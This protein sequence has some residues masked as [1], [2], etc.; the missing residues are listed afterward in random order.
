MDTTG[1][2]DLD[3][4]SGE[5]RADSLERAVRRGVLAIRRRFSRLKSTNRAIRQGRVSLHINGSNEAVF[6]PI[7]SSVP[8]IPPTSSHRRATTFLKNALFLHP[9]HLGSMGAEVG[10]FSKT[11]GVGQPFFVFA[12]E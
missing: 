10:R 2:E 1:Y 4:G 9:W 3:P 11:R 7:H 12:R 5:G 6:L 8:Y